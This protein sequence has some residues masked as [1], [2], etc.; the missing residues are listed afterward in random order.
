MGALLSLL[1]ACTPGP[2][3][4]SDTGEVSQDGGGVDVGSQ[5]A[6]VDAGMPWRPEASDCAETLDRLSLSASQQQRTLRLADQEVLHASTDSPAVLD[7]A[8]IDGQL[9]LRALGSGHATVHLEGATASQQVLVEVT[10][11]PTPF[12]QRVVEVQYGTSAGFGQGDMPAIVLGPPRG[13]GAQAGSLDVV[14][15]GVGGHITLE[16]GVD[17]ADGPGP[18]LIVFE[19]AFVDA[20]SGEVSYVEPAQVAVST[21]GTTF[22][23]FPCDPLPPHAGCAGLAPV[24]AHPLWPVDATDP[25]S[26]GGDAFDLASLGLERARYVRIT[27]VSPTS[28]GGIAAGFDLDAVVAVHGV[29]RGRVALIGPAT[30]RMNPDSSATPRLDLRGPEQSLFGVRTHCALDDLAV[31]TLECDCTLRARSTGHTILR[32][33]LGTLSTTIAVEVVA[34]P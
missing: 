4:G 31:A 6:Q 32:A 24:L 14:A 19:N 11:Q 25:A 10:A 16:L 7:L 29:P 22:V 18:D 21:D 3:P 5:D 33:R 20:L 27:D 23:D 1:L 9:A 26:A 2:E 30:L 28:A 15:L 13:G 12:G 8:M 17:L 34:G